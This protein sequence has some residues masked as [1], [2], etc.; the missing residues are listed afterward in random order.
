MQQCTRFSRHNKKD[1]ESCPVEKSCKTFGKRA[2]EIEDGI[3]NG[4]ELHD[5]VW[6][7]RNGLLF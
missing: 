4:R 1:T 5:V 6:R 7:N 3:G 2:G